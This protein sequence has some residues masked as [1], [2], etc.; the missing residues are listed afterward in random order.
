MQHTSLSSG[1]GSG[2][3]THWRGTLWA[4]QLTSDQLNR[5]ASDLIIREF[6][7]GTVVCRKGAPVDA[8][9]GVLEGLVKISS[10]SSEGK[11]VTFAGVPAGGWFGEG[12]VLKPACLRQYDVVA[13]RD[14]RVAFMPRNTFLWLVDTSLAFNRF[15]LTQLNERLAQFIATVEFDR[16]LDP[17]ARVARYLAQLFNPHLYPDTDARLQISQEEIG[18]LSGVSRQRVNQALQTLERAQLVRLE[19]GAVTVLDVAGLANYPGEA[20][21]PG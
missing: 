5:V 20:S 7:G 12:S 13:L 15:L 9:T 17:E 10:V 14:S 1:G 21:R 3:E 19:Y 4:R 18:Y 11:A 8:W 16:L 6:P 2:Q